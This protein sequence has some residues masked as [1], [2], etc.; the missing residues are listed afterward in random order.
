VGSSSLREELYNTFLKA[1]ASVNVSQPEQLINASGSGEEAQMPPESDQAAREQKL[2]AKKE[3]AVREREIKVRAERGRLD[4]DIS[5]SR[6]G[7]NQGEGEQ[8]FK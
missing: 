4:M 7:L 3:Q 2:K 8:Q 5:R 1:G 6:M